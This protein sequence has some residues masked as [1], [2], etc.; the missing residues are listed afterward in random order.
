[1]P[2]ATTEMVVEDVA[3]TGGVTIRSRINLTH[4]AAVQSCRRR[5]F[6]WEEEDDGATDSQPRATAPRDE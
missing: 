2:A 3:A 6:N 5:L 1:M 4:W